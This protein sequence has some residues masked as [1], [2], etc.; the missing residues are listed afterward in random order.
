MALRQQP[1]TMAT[2]RQHNGY[3]TSTQRLHNGSTTATQRLG[4]EE[5]KMYG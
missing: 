2:Q 4:V 5:I 1:N 3:T